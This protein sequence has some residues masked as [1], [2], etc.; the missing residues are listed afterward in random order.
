M[1][2]VKIIKNEFEF[3]QLNQIHLNEFPPE[4]SH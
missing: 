3:N 4:I 2:D 1:K